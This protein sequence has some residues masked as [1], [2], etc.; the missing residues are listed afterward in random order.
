M[1]RVISYKKERSNGRHAEVISP[2]PIYS[3]VQSESQ[4]FDRKTTSFPRCLLSPL[5][6]A[7]PLINVSGLFCFPVRSL[8]HASPFP[9]S[10][11]PLPKRLARRALISTCSMTRAAANEKQH[12]ASGLMARILFLASAQTQRDRPCL[13]NTT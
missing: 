9:P 1:S 2:I 12:E 8:N 7:H 10:H 13:F 5:P 4:M 6:S 3:I 11:G